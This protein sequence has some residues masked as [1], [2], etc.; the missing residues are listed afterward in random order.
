MKPH[1]SLLT[2]ALSLGAATL[3]QA[4]IIGF[5]QLGGNNTTVPGALGSN[6]MADG[7]GFVVSNGTTPNI[8]LT[9]DAAWDIHTSPQFNTLENLT[10]GGGAWDNEG[11]IPRI[12]QLD[13]PNHTINFAADTGFAL[14]LNSFD[15]GH[16]PETAGTSVWDIRLRDS[17]MNVVWSS[18]GLTLPNTSVTLSPNFTG[19]L[20]EDYSL[21]FNRVSQTYAAEGRHGLDNLSF[22]QAVPEPT[23]VAFLG[24]AGLALLARRRR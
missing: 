15:F 24:L 9:W 21:S 19:A 16:T 3:G 1:F 7:N 13:T 4:T 2:M 8:A 5:G 22:N 20:G 6:A 18:L 14:V 10:A 23:G 12:A 17:G 11:S